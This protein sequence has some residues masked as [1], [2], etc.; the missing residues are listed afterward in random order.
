MMATIL[1][2]RRCGFGTQGDVMWLCIMCSFVLA[3]VLSTQQ[4][5]AVVV[6]PTGLL[7][8][9]DT[10]YDH[11]IQGT[12]CHAGHGL[13]RTTRQHTR[14][15]QHTSKFFVCVSLLDHS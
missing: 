2:G 10:E 4:V 14:D 7:L 3:R 9:G 15:A 11:T 6:T 13:C 1:S 12:E 8:V 5:V